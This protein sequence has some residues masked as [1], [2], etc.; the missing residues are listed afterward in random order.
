MGVQ[1][2]PQF[3]SGAVG[4]GAAIRMVVLDHADILQLVN[5]WTGGIPDFV[6]GIDV[7]HRAHIS[8][9]VSRVQ[10]VS[11]EGG[12]ISAKA[13]RRSTGRFQR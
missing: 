9:E 6:P 8:E 5:N 4:L 13:A 1:S 10:G 11:E 3:H 12:E 2:S 7:V